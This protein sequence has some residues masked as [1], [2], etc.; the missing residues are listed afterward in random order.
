[1]T[2]YIDGDYCCYIL[3]IA[4]ITWKLWLPLLYKL[5]DMFINFRNRKKDNE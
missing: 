2:I 3:L 4:F 5:K 1:M